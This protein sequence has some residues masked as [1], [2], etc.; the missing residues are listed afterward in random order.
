MF[1]GKDMG[2][3][4]ELEEQL[5]AHG[6]KTGDAQRLIEEIATLRAKVSFYES[7]IMEMHRLCAVK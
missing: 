2:Y 6:D 5:R 1:L 3:W 7:R 4:I